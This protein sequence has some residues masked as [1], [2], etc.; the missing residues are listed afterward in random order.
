MRK[1]YRRKI[2]SPDFESLNKVLKGEK[3]P[4][5]VYFVEYGVDGEVMKFI[6]EEVIGEKWISTS[7]VSTGK[8]PAKK[9]FTLEEKTKRL[10][11]QHINF[12]YL[13][14]YDY[15]PSWGQLWGFSSSDLIKNLYSLK[16]RTCDDTAILSRGKRK[17]VEEKKGVITSWKDFEKFSLEKMKLYVKRHD[18]E[19]YDKFLGENLPEGMKTMVQGCLFQDV[20]D[21]LLG[22]EGLSFS[23]Y[24]QPDLVEA[25]FNTWGEV[26]YEFYENTIPMESAGGIFHADDLGYKTATMLKPDILRK[27]VF[28][29]FRKYASLAHKY[30][31]PYWYHCCGNVSQIMKDLIEDVK[32]DA[33]HSFQDVIIPVGEFKKKYGDKIATLGGIDMD[34]L[35]QSNEDNLRKYVR[36]VLDECMP[37]RYALGSGNTIANYIPVENYLIMLEEGSKWKKQT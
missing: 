19:A 33:F 10:W 24:D 14:G 32:I 34:E 5:K 36:G 29:W 22:Y 31:K 26:V 20:L 6:T 1:F 18:F 13:M 7:Q 17:W 8:A 2:P 9:G 27:L 23:L 16:T 15:V 28:P 35:A 37:G 12:F 30:G 3:Q 4:E 11:K 25:V 21:G